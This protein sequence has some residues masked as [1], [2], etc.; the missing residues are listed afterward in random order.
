MKY[1]G[2]HNLYKYMW[3]WLYRK[4]APFK[5]APIA[6]LDTAPG[7]G[8]GVEKTLRVRIFLGVLWCRR[9]V[10]ISWGC[11]PHFLRE[12]GGSSPPGTTMDNFRYLK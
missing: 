11:K 6:E 3:R 10:A 4:T 5:Y 7:Y 2:V 1:V 8:P 12:Y 9:L